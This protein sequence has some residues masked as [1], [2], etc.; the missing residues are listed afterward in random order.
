MISRMMMMR[1]VP[2]PMYMRAFIPRRSGKHALG[3]G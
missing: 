2:I 1:R 3:S